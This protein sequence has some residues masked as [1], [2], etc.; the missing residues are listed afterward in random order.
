MLRQLHWR[1]QTRNGHPLNV[2]VQSL[3]PDGAMA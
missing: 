1:N 3:I 2:Q